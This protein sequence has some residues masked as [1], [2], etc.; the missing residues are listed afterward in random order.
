MLG[1]VGVTVPLAAA[2]TQAQHS[3][4]LAAAAAA[5]AAAA[6]V[7]YAAAAGVVAAECL[8][9]LAPPRQRSRLI[10]AG[11]LLPQGFFHAT[12]PTSC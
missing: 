3:P 2:C 5:A 10:V 11:C 6:Y 8:R 1:G 9:G 7:P 12:A 4:L